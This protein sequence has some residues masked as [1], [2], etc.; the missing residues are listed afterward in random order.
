MNFNTSE[1]NYFQKDI[2]KIDQLFKGLYS[3]GYQIPLGEFNQMISA[4]RTTKGKFL[5]KED[6]LRTMNKIVLNAIIP[7]KQQNDYG[8]SRISRKT[9]N[10]NL[11]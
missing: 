10:T 7:K 4:F 9:S 11:G 8:E 2:I 1:T 3:I 6:F 5:E